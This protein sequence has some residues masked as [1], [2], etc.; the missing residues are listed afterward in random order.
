MLLT[1]VCNTENS[2]DREGNKKIILKTSREKKMEGK[3]NPDFTLTEMGWY[4]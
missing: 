1:S 2:R 3:K 4:T